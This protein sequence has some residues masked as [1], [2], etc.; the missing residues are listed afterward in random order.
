VPVDHK[1]RRGA[2]ADKARPYHR[3]VP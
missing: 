2:G 3:N 1:A